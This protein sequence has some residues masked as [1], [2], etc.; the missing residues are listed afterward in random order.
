MRHKLAWLPAAGKMQPFTVQRESPPAGPNRTCGMP[1]SRG[2]LVGEKE[3]FAFVAGI[4]FAR[5]LVGLARNG[6][7][8]M[9][10]PSVNEIRNKRDLLLVT[11]DRVFLRLL[12]S[13]GRTK[14]GDWIRKPQELRSPRCVQRRELRRI[15][16]SAAGPGVPKWRHTVRAEC[17]W[18]GERHDTSG[19]RARR[20]CNGSGVEAG[21]GMKACKSFGRQSRRKVTRGSEWLHG[22][23]WTGPGRASRVG[24]GMGLYFRSAA[25]TLPSQFVIGAR[26]WSRRGPLVAD[27]S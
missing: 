17:R 5:T 8:V 20:E 9:E 19:I 22:G 16:S 3:M 14:A 10:S 1:S 21:Q 13:E 15:Q 12:S 27:C 7:S 26:A 4:D 24:E 25:P 11:S 18:E 2:S 23:A 6:S